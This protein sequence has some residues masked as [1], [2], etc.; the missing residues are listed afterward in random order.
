V[1]NIDFE[2]LIKANEIFESGTSWD[3]DYFRTIERRDIWDDLK[4]LNENNV[5]NIILKFLN[6]WK[7][8]ISYSRTH[9]ILEV[10]KRID[11]LFT[12]LK[13]ED[14][15]SITFDKFVIVD[16]QKLQIKEVIKKIYEDLSP[17]T[18]PPVG[19]AGHTATSK[20]M[21]M[22]NPEL[23]V[24]W[25]KKIRDNYGCYG[26]SEGYV[27]FLQKMQGMIKELIKNYSQTHNIR[28][29]EAKEEIRKKCHDLKKTLAKLID[30]YNY[31]KFTRG[32]I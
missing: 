22:V 29:E 10:L 6:N 25:D 30:Q 24:M 20:I 2:D 9:E 19:K 28:E 15:V 18:S 32:M 5:R 26:S 23:F 14:I 3:T 17:V 12:C 21:H 13:D 16:E 11:N 7:C 8:R 1:I 27:N 4:N 31:L